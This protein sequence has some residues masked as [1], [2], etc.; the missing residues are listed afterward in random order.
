MWSFHCNVP[1]SRLVTAIRA[2]Y[3]TDVGRC[4][5]LKSHQMEY[6]VPK[7]ILL[8]LSLKTAM[9]ILSTVHIWIHSLLIAIGCED[10]NICINKNKIRTL[11]FHRKPTKVS[12]P[13]L[14]TVLYVHDEVTEEG[15]MDSSTKHVC[16]LFPVPKWVNIV[17]S[18]QSM[19]RLISTQTMI[20]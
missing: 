20:S 14:H 10:T 13:K 18:N 1:R 19:W 16:W 3:C 7:G 8:S 4:V 12:T 5:A 15:W 9:Q 6:D 11:C 2:T 17:V